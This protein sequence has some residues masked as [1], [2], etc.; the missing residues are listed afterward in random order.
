M[1]ALLAATGGEP[2]E[3]VKRKQFAMYNFEILA[4]Y[5]LSQ[6]LIVENSESFLSLFTSTLQDGD[7]HVKVA[8][9]K[10]ISSFLSQID[11]TSVVLK[12]A[13]MMPGLLDVVIA[14][15]QQDELQ[16]QA[17]LEAMIELTATHGDVWKGCL[18]KLID[19][20]SEVIKHKD[21]EEATRSSALEL[22]TSL[23]ENMAA[24][25]RKE[26]E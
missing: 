9:L 7:I 24:L 6:E 26:T 25:L 21:F 16:G 10:A 2:A 3:H 23:A 4:E 19:V 14:V 15:L 11:D 1:T 13:S 18:S 12:Y 17:S 20:V 22:I 8:A 5:H